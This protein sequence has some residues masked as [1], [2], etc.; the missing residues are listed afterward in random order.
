[1]KVQRSSGGNGNHS[2][3]NSDTNKEGSRENGE[4]RVDWGVCG[5][6]SQENLL[7]VCM[8]DIRERTDS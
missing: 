2:V 1:M 6:W 8:W 3:D 4:H 5:R 7:V